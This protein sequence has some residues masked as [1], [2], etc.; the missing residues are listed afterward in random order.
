MRLYYFVV[1]TSSPQSVTAHVIDVTT[2]NISWS[3]PVPEHRNGLIQ[4]YVIRVTEL[5]TGILDQFVTTNQSIIIRG[6]HPF[7]RYN[8]S[9]AAETIGLGPYSVAK[10]I[11]MPEAGRVTSLSILNKSCGFLCMLLGLSFAFRCVYSPHP[12]NLL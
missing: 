1:P 6:R 3:P 12:I 5:D 2:L 10:V 4:R 8:Y 11:H 9:I 7:Y